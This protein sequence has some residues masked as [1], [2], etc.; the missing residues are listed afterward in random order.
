MQLTPAQRRLFI[1]PVQDPTVQT[2]HVLVTEERVERNVNIDTVVAVRKDRHYTDYKHWWITEAG[3]YVLGAPVN[4]PN[5]NSYTHHLIAPG[6]DGWFWLGQPGR[7]VDNGYILNQVKRS[8]GRQLPGRGATGD[9][10]LTVAQAVLAAPWAAE[11]FPQSGDSDAVVRAKLNLAEQ[12]WM[13][14]RA[15]AEITRQGIGRGWDDDLQTLR[16][17]GKLPAPS[18]AAFYRGQAMIDTFSTTVAPSDRDAERLQAIRDRVTTYGGTEVQSMIGVSVS[19]P[20]SV[21]VSS[22]EE[23]RNLPLTSVREALRSAISDYSAVPG[24]FSITPALRSI[25]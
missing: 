25:A 21:N 24:E 15:K 11:L 10:S 1:D 22:F 19:V 8:D 6:G 14:R 20:L 18:F 7:R 4:P 12:R 9:A 2:T 23:V 17:D 13:H 5:L 16:D 3:D